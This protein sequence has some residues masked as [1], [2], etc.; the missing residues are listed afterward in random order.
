MRN[1]LH[2]IP[3]GTQLYHVEL[4]GNARECFLESY[5]TRCIE[6]HFN[7]IVCL[8]VLIYLWWWKGISQSL[9]CWSFMKSVTS[10]C[11][12]IQIS[13]LWV[14]LLYFKYSTRGYCNEQLKWFKLQ[15]QKLWKRHVQYWLHALVAYTFSTLLYSFT[16]YAVSGISIEC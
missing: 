4:N 6:L 13:K 8:S 12:S 1:S 15:W 3:S 11:Y 16:H 9:K 5:R 2:N 10:R 14:H 7:N